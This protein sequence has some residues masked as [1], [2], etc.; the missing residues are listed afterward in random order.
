LIP[1]TIL[2]VYLGME[3]G[4]SVGRSLLSAATAKGEIN[5][6]FYM[7][8]PAPYMLILSTAQSATFSR[9]DLLHSSPADRTG[10]VLGRR[11]S[12]YFSFAFLTSVL[13]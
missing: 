13:C 8:L 6:L 1:L 10:L 3:E 5:V 11:A 4:K 2:Y 12:P 9:L 7:A